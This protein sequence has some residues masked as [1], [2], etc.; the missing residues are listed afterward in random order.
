MD[1][2]AFKV[3]AIEN[4]Q[5]HKCELNISGVGLLTKFSEKGRSEV[6][7]DYDSNTGLLTSRVDSMSGVSICILLHTTNV[8]KSLK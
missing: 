8:D 5:D 3:S 2:Y 6:V 4:T 1:C 7:L